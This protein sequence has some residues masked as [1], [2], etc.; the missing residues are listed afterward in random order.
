MTP[1]IDT[2]VEQIRD[3]V[4]HDAK[5]R[6]GDN[7]ATSV[8][9]FDDAVARLRTVIAGRRASVDAQLSAPRRR[10]VGH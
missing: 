3:A 5:R 9:V 8:Q 4:L 2:R 6:G 10:S 7:P 1:R